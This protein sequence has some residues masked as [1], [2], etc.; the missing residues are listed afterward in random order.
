[1]AE[2]ARGPN[3]GAKVR[4]A[5]RPEAIQ[6]AKERMHERAEKGE[7]KDHRI[8]VGLHE[9]EGQQPKL[10]YEGKEEPITLAQVMTIHEFGAGEYRDRS[11]LRTWF[12][13]NRDRLAKEMIAVARAGYRGDGGAFEEQAQQW[14]TELREWVELEDAN[15]RPLSPVTIKE[16]DRAGL[17]QPTTPLVATHQFVSALKAMLDGKEVK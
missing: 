11:W 14:A 5:F 10:N 9:E 2:H 1:M 17:D 3:G 13:Q 7:A 4:V 16:K 12:D 15:L 6:R 8:T